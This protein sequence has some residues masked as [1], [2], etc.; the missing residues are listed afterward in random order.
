MSSPG[1][2][3]RNWRL[4]V[5]ALAL[6]VLL[7]VTMRLRDDADIARRDLPNVDVRVENG[8]P[9]WFLLGE[10]SPGAVRMSVQGSFGDLF[11]VALARPSIVIPIDSVPGED[12]IL[13]LRPDWVGGVDPSRVTITEFTPSTVRLR[14]GMNKVEPI[15]VSVRFTG[16]VPDSLAVVGEPRVNPLFTQV[17]GAASVVDGLEAVFLEPF[18]LGRLEGPGSGR[19]ELSLDTVGLGGVVVNPSAASLVVNVA[20]RRTRELGHRGVELPDAADLVLEPDS[21]T[22]TLFGAEE[23]L[24]VID[25][26]TVRL[27]VATSARVIRQALGEVTEVRAPVVVEGLPRWIEGSAGADSVTVRRAGES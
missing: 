10:P 8:D 3:L 11:R 6:A 18:D 15:P 4:K 17:R 22:V 7:W 24:G 27:R 2:V 14:F 5:A 21:L 12:W 9:T 13:E 20:L 26:S 25:V 1:I 23:M 16:T 19:F